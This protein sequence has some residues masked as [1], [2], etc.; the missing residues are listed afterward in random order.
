MSA[1]GRVLLLGRQWNSRLIL[2]FMIRTLVRQDRSAGV[3]VQL[4]L[5]QVGWKPTSIN[6]CWIHLSSSQQLSPRQ[7]QMW[8]FV[9]ISGRLISSSSSPGC[10]GLF[11]FPCMQCQTASDYGWCCCMPCLDVCCA[12]SCILRSNIRERHGIP[13]SLVSGVGG[14]SLWHDWCSYRT[15]L[16]DLHLV[17]QQRWQKWCFFNFEEQSSSLNSIR[18]SEQKGGAFPVGRA[19]TD[20]C[21]NI[22]R[23]VCWVLCDG[24]FLNF[25]NEDNCGCPKHVS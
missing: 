4:S 10:F 25:L 12:V 15:F 24:Y 20:S 19:A 3:K 17:S 22:I 5:Q 9:F 6:T 21:M 7:H 16:A 18:G 2:Y 8:G 14:G 11:C 1:T 13:V 23:N